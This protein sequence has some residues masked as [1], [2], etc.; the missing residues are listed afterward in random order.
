MLDAEIAATLM[1]RW[2]RK[3][4]PA[5]NWSPLDLLQEGKLHYM[6]R[7][8]EF[9]ARDEAGRATHGV[10]VEYLTFADGSRALRITTAEGQDDWSRWVAIEAPRI[11]LSRICE[12]LVDV[13]G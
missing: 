1:N 6:H 5:G 9:R 7:R 4:A 12:D 13:A 2:D 11:C 8:G 3:P 10:H